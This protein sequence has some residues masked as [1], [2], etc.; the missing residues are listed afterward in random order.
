M[1]VVKKDKK[2][3]GNCKYKPGMVSVIIELMKHGASKYEVCAEL[4]ITTETLHQWCNKDGDYF[5]ADIAHAVKKGE[6]LSRA[7]WEKQ[8]RLNL[9]GYGGEGAEKF[10]HVLW[11]MNMKNRHKWSDKTEQTLTANVSHSIDADILEQ[12]RSEY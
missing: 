9:I 10:N 7:W 11:Y 8:G 1:S 12:Y 2:P 4:D 3:H 5:I 6:L